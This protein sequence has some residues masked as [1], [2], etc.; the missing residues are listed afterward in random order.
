MDVLLDAAGVR[1]AGLGFAVCHE[2]N[3]G[4]AHEV[5]APVGI[6]VGLVLLPHPPDLDDQV[7]AAVVVERRVEGEAEPVVQFG[8]KL[9]GVAVEDLRRRVA[10][11]VVGVLL[12]QGAPRG[13]A[14]LDAELEIFTGLDLLAYAEP[15]PR[16]NLPGGQRVRGQYEVLHP[17]GLAPSTTAERVVAVRAPLADDELVRRGR[18]YAR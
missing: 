8:V 1:V 5:P 4:P 17:A 16:R 13:V 6:G 18:G 7:V 10:G 15:L 14:K 12:A 11:V 3:D 9:H 2:R